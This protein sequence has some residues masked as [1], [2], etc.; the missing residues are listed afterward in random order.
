M[1]FS[2][3]GYGVSRDAGT[4]VLDMT[5]AKIDINHR[6]HRWFVSHPIVSLLFLFL[7][8][9]ISFAGSAGSRVELV[10]GT[11]INGEVISMTNAR[12]IIRSP[13]L[14]QIE[15]PQSSIRT[16]QPTGNT[17]PSSSANEDIQVIQQ[18]IVASP[19]LMQLVTVLM[20]DPEIQKALKDP[21]FMQLIMSGNLQA[22]KD[23]PRTLRLMN[24]PSMQAILDEMR[25]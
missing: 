23:D 20:S 17:A 7:L 25:H 9:S 2:D 24:N 21:E 18:Q 4:Q 22:L 13:T 5:Q 8:A 10:D 15:L 14:G 11:I 6:H 1:L 3:K 16:I 19:E 12:Y